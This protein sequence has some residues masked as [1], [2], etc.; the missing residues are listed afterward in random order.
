MGLDIEFS[1][2]RA[3]ELTFPAGAQDN[4]TA[5]DPADAS[6]G[7]AGDQ[8]VV[9]HVP[10]HHGAC[11]HHGPAPDLDG[12]DADRVGADG[13]ALSDCHAD[14]LPIICG[15]LRSIHVDRTGEY[16]I[17]EDRGGADEDSVFK[18][19]GLIDERVILHLAVLA[20]DDS[21]PNVRTT[22]KDAAGAEPRILANL[23]EVPDH[24]AGFEDGAWIDVCRRRN[25]RRAG[26]PVLGVR[27]S[28][29]IAHRTPAI[30]AGPR[31]EAWQRNARS[32]GSN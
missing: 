14:H 12:C 24:G 3:N 23:G 22:S 9:G 32:P 27:A 13:G 30:R 1:G 16:V 17:R 18:Q 31:F 5:P 6:G 2:R 28:A 7:N 15:F 26:G 11:G 10:R 19:G 8:G 21:R 29:R 4:A 20:E 25:L